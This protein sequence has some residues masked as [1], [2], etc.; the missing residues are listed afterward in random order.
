MISN[1][2][3][4]TAAGAISALAST[5]AIV[6][7]ARRKATGLLAPG[8]Q[9]AAGL[10]GL[11]AGTALITLSHLLL[12]DKEIDVE[13]ILSEEELDLMDTNLSATL[14]ASA[15]PVAKPARGSRIEVD[16]EATIEDFM[17]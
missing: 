3:I 10:S 5:V 13:E 1:K 12:E 11:A 4:V 14:G 6:D 15:E 17:E 2:W 9:L 16:E 7:F 8:Y